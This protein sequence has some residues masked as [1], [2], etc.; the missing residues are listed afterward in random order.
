MSENTINNLVRK[1]KEYI[2]DIE[3]KEFLRKEVVWGYHFTT[4]NGYVISV[5]Y[6]P[7]TYSDHHDTD[8]SEAV[9]VVDSLTAEIAYWKQGGDMIVFSHGDTVL[10]YQTLAECI[11]FIRM[12]ASDTFSETEAA[13]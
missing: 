4:P 12:V 11:E 5:Q 7:G 3:V 13:E 9:G 1:I 2:P 10:G 6:A 8:F